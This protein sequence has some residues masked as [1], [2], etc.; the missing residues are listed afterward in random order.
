MES[1]SEVIQCCLEVHGGDREK[2][3]E[4]MASM[5]QREWPLLTI[6]RERECSLERVRMTYEHGSTGW[7]RLVPTTKLQICFAKEPNKRDN[8]LQERPI[9]LSILLTVATL[10]ESASMNMAL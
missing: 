8:I 6:F 2:E 3:R 9:I 10:Y 4:R 5:R 1:A 7:L